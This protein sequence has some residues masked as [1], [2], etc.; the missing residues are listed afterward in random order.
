MSDLDSS[1]S[2]RDFGPDELNDAITK[3]RALLPSAVDALCEVIAEVTGRQANREIVKFVGSFWLMHACDQE[4]YGQSDSVRRLIVEATAS[5]ETPRN[6]R[7]EAISLVGSYSAP[8][9]IVDPY[10][11]TS[12]S[13]EILGAF[14]A[15]KKLCW[16][17]VP[18]N[19]ETS[20]SV[21][22]ER[23]I[24]AALAFARHDGENTLRRSIALSA[25]VELVE[26][27]HDLVT[28]SEA[29]SDPRARILYSA[30]AH[31][32]S[33]KFRYLLFQ[34]RLQGSK[35][36]FHQHGGGYGIDEQHP[37]EFHDTLL[38]DVFYSW[39]WNR[40][41]LGSKVRPLPTASP[42]RDKGLTGRHYL[43]M[44]FQ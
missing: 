14:K 16:Q 6:R 30:N 29:V 8:V 17:S 39:G 41:D 26:Q 25:P 2:G 38:G 4:I 11:K 18:P 40:P 20:F 23:R 31:Q 32:S 22:R 21:Q 24:S 37:G 28:W 7:S 33:A 35:I 42:A 5:G 9:R 15:R 1:A 36:V 27:H 10:L 12:F 13:K 43:L 3:S 19:R 44:S 34:Q